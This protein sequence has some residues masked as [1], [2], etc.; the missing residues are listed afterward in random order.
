MRNIE[1]GSSDKSFEKEVE[2]YFLFTGTVPMRYFL[3]AG[4]VPMRYFL[5]TGTV[6]VNN[7]VQ[8][9]F[10]FLIDGFHYME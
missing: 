4:T 8:F 6:P 3:F 10:Y 9:I 1:F 5:F 7:L 2:N